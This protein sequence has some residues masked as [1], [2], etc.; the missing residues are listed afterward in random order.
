M[1]ITKETPKAYVTLATSDFS[2]LTWLQ[3]SEPFAPF[4]LQ[5]LPQSSSSLSLHAELRDD[6]FRCEVIGDFPETEART[7]LQHVVGKLPGVDNDWESMH[8]DEDQYWSLW[9]ESTPQWVMGG[10]VA[11][12]DWAHIY[13][14]R[15]N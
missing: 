7:F 14:V 8:P 15:S 5:P 13:E 4:S 11:D 10:P 12:Q 3:A 9:S 2:V 1:Q 6:L